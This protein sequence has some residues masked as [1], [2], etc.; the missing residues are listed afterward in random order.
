MCDQ[1]THHDRL[2]PV[3]SPK[4]S[5][6]IIYLLD[7]NICI[8][9][10]KGDRRVIAKLTQNVGRIHLGM[11]VVAELQ[12]GIEKLALSNES[13]A[14]DKRSSLQR[15]IDTT[16]GIVELSSNV[17]PI[18]A[19]I[20]ANLDALGIP[21]GAHDLWIA[22]QAIYEGATLVSANTREFERIP[23]LRLQNWL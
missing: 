12:F 10:L 9:A 22:A 20:R 5:N 6:S 13:R 16:D 14:T 17:I 7:T 2:T 23:Q 11:L 3:G 8:A 4:R 21:I 18:Y 1:T 15:F 19:Q